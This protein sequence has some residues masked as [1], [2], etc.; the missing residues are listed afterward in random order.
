VSAGVRR[1]RGHHAMPNSASSPG[2]KQV[3]VEHIGT[4]P[5]RAQDR[6]RAIA[7]L[8]ALIT[9]WQHD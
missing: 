2:S 5:I 6:E 9:A 7:T 1:Q 8:A 3:T 4:E